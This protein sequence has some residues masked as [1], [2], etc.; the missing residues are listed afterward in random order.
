MKHLLTA[1]ACFFALSMS[2]QFIPQPMGYNPDSN[3]DAFVGID[4]LMAVLSLYGT[5]FDNGD[6]VQIAELSFVGNYLDTLEIPESADIIYIYDEI[7]FGTNSRHLKLPMGSGFKS[8]MVVPVI[9][10][11]S[12]EVE[13]IPEIPYAHYPNFYSFL[14]PCNEQ[15]PTP[16]PEYFSLNTVRV[17]VYNRLHKLYVRMPNGNWTFNYND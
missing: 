15:Y 3:S 1:I 4:D 13:D 16:C 7:V 5:P 14:V 9:T 6:S 10:Q 12:A 8:I 17:N 11:T 2:A